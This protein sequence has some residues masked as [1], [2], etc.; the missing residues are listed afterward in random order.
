MMVIKCLTL[1]PGDGQVLQAFERRFGVD[2]KRD[3]DENVSSFA[4]RVKGD[5]L[6]RYTK[7]GFG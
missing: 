2:S 3:G 1:A 6:V 4:K 5:E 7:Y